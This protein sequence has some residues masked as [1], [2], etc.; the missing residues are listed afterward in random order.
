MIICTVFSIPSI[1]FHRQDI[2]DD[3]LTLTTPQWWVSLAVERHWA[4]H[5]VSKCR[6]LS[7]IRVSM[8]RNGAE[9][10]C[11]DLLRD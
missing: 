1:V 6:T 4:P 10:I 2:Y 11:Q 5:V 9:L 7:G 3:F 8:E